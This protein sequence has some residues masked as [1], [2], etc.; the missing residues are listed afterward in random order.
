M[1]RL[2]R[3]L[4]D[5]EPVA[6]FQ[7]HCGLFPATSEVGER[8]AR[9][10]VGVG[11][12]GSRPS[13][14]W[15]VRDFGG[16]AASP[17]HRP[18]PPADC[19][20]RNGS[21]SN[22]RKDHLHEYVVKNYFYYYL[23]TISAAMGQEVFYI[24]FLPFTYWNIN[25]YVGRRLIIMWSVVMYIGQ[26]TKDLLKWPR[27]CS[28]PV[29]KLEKRAI[30][31]YGMPS[32]HAM[33]STTISFTFVIATMNIY[34]YHFELGLMGAF[35]FST[36]VGL[37]RIYTGMHTVL[38]VI[39]GSLISGLLVALMYPTWD[40]LDHLMITSPW[41]PIF[42]IVVP[43]LLCYNY[44]KL[45]YYS[46]TKADTTTILGA[47]AGSGVGFWINNHSVTNYSAELVSPP[48]ITA[49]M[50][51]MALSKFLVGIC[52]LVVIRQIIKSMAL[53]ALCSWYKVSVDDPIAGHRTEIE[54]PYK[55]ITYFSIGLSATVLVPLLHEVL[56]LN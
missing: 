48:S 30:A 41:C 28:P 27:P 47:S 26:V 19:A 8:G 18:R 46:P 44:P 37:S 7:R 12:G 51:L 14:T 21:P 24:T 13:G 17:E 9:R 15:D 43:L 39:V 11:N 5:S 29:V 53:R 56:R 22:S 10:A 6:R 1:A 38:D 3:S 34:K 32:T 40:F 23:F 52:F 36:L 45:D 42:C 50:V 4:R 2:V 54:V 16:D 49:E 55:F 31:E 35:V 33:A 20:T 25:P